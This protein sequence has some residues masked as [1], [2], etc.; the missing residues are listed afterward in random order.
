VS[1][2]LYAKSYLKE[3]TERL[4]RKFVDET[5]QN[6]YRTSTGES[7][8]DRRSTEQGMTEEDRY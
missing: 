2:R 8:Q 7:G 3:V 1:S 5:V 4:D 6:E